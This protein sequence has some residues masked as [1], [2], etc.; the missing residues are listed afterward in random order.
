MISLVCRHKNPLF[1]RILGHEAGGIVESV[2]KGVT[3]LQPGDQCFPYI[4]R[5]MQGVPLMQVRKKNNPCDLLKI[6]TDRGCMINDGKSRFS[7][8]GQP[9]YHFLGTSTFSE[10]TVIHVGQ[11]AKI[12]PAAPLDKVCALSCGV[13]TVAIFGLGVIGLAATEEHKFHELRGS[14]VLICIPADLRKPR[15]MV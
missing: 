8:N 11:V 9:I 2:D 4:H 13:S 12:N 1:P 3:D 10:Y 14:L 5:G 6:N 7:I 15:S